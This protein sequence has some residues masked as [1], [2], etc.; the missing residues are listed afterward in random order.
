MGWGSE[1]GGLRMYTA[2]MSTATSTT[3]AGHRHGRRVW[4]IGLDVV[5][6]VFRHTMFTIQ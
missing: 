5:D 4:C 6:A 3:V 1:T 2:T